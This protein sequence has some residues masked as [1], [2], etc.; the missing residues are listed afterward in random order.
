MT[1][2]L[3]ALCAPIIEQGAA[4]PIRSVS[5]GLEQ[6]HWSAADLRQPGVGRPELR[7]GQRG[8]RHERSP[9]AG[10]VGQLTLVRLR[11]VAQRRADCQQVRLVGLGAALRLRHGALDLQLAGPSPA[12]AG[13][14]PASSTLG[15]GAVGFYASRSAAMRSPSPKPWTRACAME[16]PAASSTGVVSGSVVL[17]A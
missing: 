10:V 17:P 9:A 11:K 1:I 13:P 3:T 7:L 12:I 4:A 5:A 14:Q 6:D 8:L 15:D 2:A 16:T